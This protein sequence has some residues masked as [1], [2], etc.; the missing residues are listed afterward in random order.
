MR[1]ISKITI[2][3]GAELWNIII[4]FG[5]KP[6]K[7]NA[8]RFQESKGTPERLVLMSGVERLCIQF[9]GK[10]WADSDLL[11]IEIDQKKVSEYFKSINI[12]I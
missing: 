2:Q 11:K 4:P 1:N 10:V 12:S 5:A 6:F 3:E 7:G 9:D 8:Y